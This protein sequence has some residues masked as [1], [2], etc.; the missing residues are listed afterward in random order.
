[1]SVSERTTL[2]PTSSPSRLS[3]VSACA[4][5]C[6]RAARSASRSCAPNWASRSPPS[7]ATS[8][9]SR[10]T[11][12]L[13][14]VHGGAVSVDD[15]PSRRASR[16]RPPSTAA[17]TTH[18]R[19]RIRADRTRR[20]RSTSTPA[21]PAWKLASCWSAETTSPSSPTA[22][23]P[24]SNSPAAVRAWSSS[25]VSCGRSARLSWAP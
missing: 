6:A 21:R 24:S 18:R 17:E 8:T 16:P 11:G 9:N 25:A 13:R 1:M 20:D 2:S 10:R 4:R 15:R 3:G 5:S 12:A 19:P 22:C 23:R 14:R 7:A